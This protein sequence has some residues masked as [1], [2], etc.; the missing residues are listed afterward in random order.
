MKKGFYFSLVVIISF[1]TLGLGNMGGDDVVNLPEPEQ[2][3]SVTLIDQ[4]DVSIEL[5]K[6]SCN[7]MTY[8]IGKFGKS[9]VSVDYDRID[10]VSFLLH[11]EDVKAKLHLKDGKVIELVVDKNKSCY[12]VSLFGNCRIEIQDVKNIVIHGKILKKE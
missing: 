4:S 2:N 9:E 11:N 6:F 8:F 7:G 1:C 10:S 5:E 3:Y 12:G